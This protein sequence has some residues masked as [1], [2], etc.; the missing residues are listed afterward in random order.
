MGGWPVS[1]QAA[2]TK[3]D[4]ATMQGC[5]CDGGKEDKH[6]ANMDP[7]FCSCHGLFVHHCSSDWDKISESNFNKVLNGAL[8]WKYLALIFSHHVLSRQ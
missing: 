1:L 7:A 4:A 6:L 3:C 8:N 2:T 5:H